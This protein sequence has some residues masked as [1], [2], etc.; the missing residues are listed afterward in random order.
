MRG[1]WIGNGVR[2]RGV[3]SVIVR[4]LILILSEKGVMEVGERYVLFR[5][6]EVLWLLR[7]EI[8]GRRIRVE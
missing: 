8:I 1:D 2:S 5:V 4:I 3:L 6:V 7:G